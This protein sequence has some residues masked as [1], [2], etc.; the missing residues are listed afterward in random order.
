LWH[1]LQDWPNFCGAVAYA[2]D[3]ALICP[4]PAATRRLLKI[5]DD[6]ASQ[7]D[8]SFNANKSKFQLINYIIIIIIFYLIILF[9]LVNHLH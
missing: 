1:L 7:H 8:I 6:F 2:D 5:C 4:T 9:T 3:S